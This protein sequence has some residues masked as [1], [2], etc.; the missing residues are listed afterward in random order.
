MKIEDKLFNL[1]MHSQGNEARK[2]DFEYAVHVTKYSLISIVRAARDIVDDTIIEETKRKTIV[3]SGL[4]MA[5]EK[6]LHELD[7]KEI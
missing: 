7:S 6:A 5:L 1:S 4:L 3:D 2:R